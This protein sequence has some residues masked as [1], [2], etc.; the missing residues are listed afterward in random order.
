MVTEAIQFST[1]E[2]LGLR[3]EEL[4]HFGSSSVELP[5]HCFHH[6]CRESEYAVLVNFLVSC[7]DFGEFFH[8]SWCW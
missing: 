3:K 1:G 7:F 2:Q 4:V 8:C 5:V 6:H